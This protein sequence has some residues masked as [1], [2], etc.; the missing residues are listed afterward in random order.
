MDPSH[1]GCREFWE[2]VSR[3]LGPEGRRWIWE[4]AEAKTADGGQI[5]TESRDTLRE[6]SE[7]EP[8]PPVSKE[9]PAAHS[10]FPVLDANRDN[11][12]DGLRSGC[13]GN[14]PTPKRAELTPDDPSSQR[15]KVG[16]LDGRL[17][18]N[19]AAAQAFADKHRIGGPVA[20]AAANI[21]DED[22]SRAGRFPTFGRPEYS[23]W[24]PTGEPG[25]FS[26]GSISHSG[27]FHGLPATQ[28]WRP[29]ENLGPSTQTPHVA[30]ATPAG[31]YAL[32]MS[33][34]SPR[35]QSSGPP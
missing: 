18:A 20:D 21:T 22:I 4:Q 34:K 13:V 23:V 11:S 7:N 29:G 19:I 30:G 16:E 25:D 8:I 1:A 10:S 26:R 28:G 9:D 12:G 15:P 31:R 3:N 6:P 27:N 33:D 24:F 32:R 5:R 14:P 35:I 2:I 17:R